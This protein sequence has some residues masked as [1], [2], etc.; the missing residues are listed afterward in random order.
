MDRLV[1][2]AGE[3]GCRIRPIDGARDG[4][5]LESGNEW[6]RDSA[7]YLLTKVEVPNVEGLLLSALT[8]KSEEIVEKVALGLGFNG[9]TPAAREALE[10]LAA[11]KDPI[12]AQARSFS[13][14]LRSTASGA[15]DLFRRR[16]A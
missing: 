15:L 1:Q 2:G 16:L 9:S 3:A 7:L 4:R 6:T 13:D 10:N 12:A 11:G 14:K 8:D 5:L